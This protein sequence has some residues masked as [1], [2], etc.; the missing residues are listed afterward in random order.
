MNTTKA[1]VTT[2]GVVFALIT[3]AHLWRI[4]AESPALARDPFFVALTVA[5][6]GFAAWAWRVGRRLGRTGA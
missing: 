3:L 2:T 1:Y 6:A 4:I 5:V